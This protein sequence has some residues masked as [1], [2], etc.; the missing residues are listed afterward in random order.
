MKQLEDPEGVGP[1]PQLHEPEPCA[2]ETPEGTQPIPLGAQSPIQPGGKSPVLPFEAYY[3]PDSSKFYVE[4]PSTGWLSQSV[5]Q[6][7]RRLKL[8]GI[9]DKTV[10]DRLIQNIEDSRRIR[11]AAP[12]AGKMAG[13]FV[14]NNIPILVTESPRL[15]DPVKGDCK[16]L[17]QLISQLLT[18]DKS[19]PNSSFLG[20][21]QLLTFHYWLKAAVKALR[22]GR[23]EQAQVLVL[24]GEAGSGKSLLQALITEMLGG[25]AAKP[26]R[27]MTS[28]TPFN[29]EL[30]EAEH[31]M[32]EDEFTGTKK[33]DRSKLGAEIKK[34]TVS[35]RLQSCHRKSRTAVNLPVFWRVT[36]S[37]NDEPESLQMLPPLDASIEDKLILLRV[38]KSPMPMPNNTA[39][40][41]EAFWHQLVSEI[42]AFLHFLL[43]ELE[44]TE[45]YRDTRYPVKTYHHPDLRRALENLSDEMRLLALIDEI[46]W[47]R[48][49]IQDWEGPA[50]ELQRLLFEDKRTAKAAQNLLD[51]TNSTGT[52]LGKL[53]KSRPNR[54]EPH[55][56]PEVRK[57]IIRRPEDMTP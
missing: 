12:L 53:A 9:S 6:L 16:K 4:I 13:Y 5:T 7:K 54:V 39:E 29:A 32:L 23:H 44:I 10:Q 56:T 1:Q 24:C 27:Y 22:E 37:L 43:N 33:V 48:P 28:K 25:R 15:I 18:N 26:E 49:D 42:P 14:E 47:D 57:W 52:L 11:Y 40:E 31:L 46:L 20:L 38:T 8:A 19:V 17:L 55:R 50:K 51:W 45:G 30:F 35:T 41:K 21:K 3:H 36:I 2:T 34:M